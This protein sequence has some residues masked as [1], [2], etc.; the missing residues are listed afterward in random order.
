MMDYVNRV[1]IHL[2][3]VLIFVGLGYRCGTK[4]SLAMLVER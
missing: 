4:W 2:Q 3:T 1:D